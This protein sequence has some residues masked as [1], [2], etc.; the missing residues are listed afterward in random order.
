M[1]LLSND[2]YVSHHGIKGQKWGVRRYQNPDGTLTSAGK[3]KLP[4]DVKR[5]SK[6]QDRF[7]KREKRAVK[8]I[9]KYRA[10]NARPFLL[11]NDLSTAIN[12]R[13]FDKVTRKYDKTLRRANALYKK[14]LDRYGRNNVASVDSGVVS[15][16]EKLYTKYAGVLSLDPEFRI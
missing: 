12:Q 2:T 13:R 7:R 10:Y 8:T 14:S 5:L 9:S 11:K 1:Q 6:L 4:R 16:G 15:F 3:N